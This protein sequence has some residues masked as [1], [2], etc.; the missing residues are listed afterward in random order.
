MSP[1]PA[2]RGKQVVEVL[3]KAGFTVGRTNGSHHIMRH[4]DGRRTTVPASCVS[5]Q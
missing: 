2:V 4:P 5:C 1:V 3:E